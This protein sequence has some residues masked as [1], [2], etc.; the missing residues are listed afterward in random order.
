[1]QQKLTLNC[2]TFPK[3]ESTNQYFM[4]VTLFITEG[5]EAHYLIWYK[6]SKILLIDFK[7]YL[8]F[9]EILPIKLLMLMIA[10]LYNRVASVLAKL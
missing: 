4:L 9:S 3:L 5:R 10:Y 7:I 1:M 8:F 2:K 6:V